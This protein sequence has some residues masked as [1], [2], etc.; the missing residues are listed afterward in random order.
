MGA[1]DGGAAASRKELAARYKEMKT[2]MGAVQVRNA[3]SGK[4]FVAAYPNLKNKWLTMQGQ[5]GF[6][7]FVNKEL[8]KDWDELGPEAFEY[9]VLEE[10]DTEGVEDVRWECKQLE[11]AWLERLQP[12]G[13]RGYNKPPKGDAR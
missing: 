11:K 7:Q 6:G 9:S 10:R 4:L 1:G 12:Y 3:R 13:D 2:Y 8:Q 5:L